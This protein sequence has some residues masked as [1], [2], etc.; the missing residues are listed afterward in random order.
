MMLA[1]GWGVWAPAEVVAQR[2]FAS[3]PGVLVGDGFVVRFALG[4]SLRAEAVAEILRAQP[5]L[6]A[7][8]A[9][10]PTGVTV[11]LAPDEETFR[12]AA[13]GR[14]PDWSAAVAVPAANR[15]VLPAASSDR[16]RGNDPWRVIRHE[17]AH[18]ALRQ[19]LPRVRVPRWFDEG[20]AQWAGGWD[21]R[22]AWRLRVRVALGRT[23]PLDSLTFRFPGD[24]GSALDAYLLSATT[25]EYLVQ[26]SGEEALALFLE[27]WRAGGRFEDALRQ[28][29]GVST[30]QLEEDWRRWLKRRYGWVTVV[31][32]S[33]VAWGLLSLIVVVLF[34]I[35]RVRDREQLARLRALEPPEAPD[36]WRIPADEPAGAL[37]GY[38]ESGPA[39]ADPVLPPTGSR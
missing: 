25:V 29:Y 19:S 9:G 23:P 34:R 11:I 15:I 8:P 33:A 31:T 3:T 12:R 35:R 4:D 39:P 24:R 13:G 7:L 5:P 38:H 26:A 30:A 21:R 28:V 22:D 17:W 14:P 27:R 36:F 2:G 16:A 10:V 18:L 1:V 6:P 32:N 20:Y 37:G